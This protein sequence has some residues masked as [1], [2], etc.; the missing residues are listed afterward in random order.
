MD[1]T[2]PFEED[3]MAKKKK[4]TLYRVQVTDS[5]IILSNRTLYPDDEGYVLVTEAEYAELK[6]MLGR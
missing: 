2:C 1:R 3:I 4:N 6:K 5:V